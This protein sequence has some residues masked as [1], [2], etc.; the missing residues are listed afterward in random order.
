MPSHVD[1]QGSRGGALLSPCHLWWG[2]QPPWHKARP[3]YGVRRDGKVPL[4]GALVWGHYHLVTCC[5]KEHCHCVAAHKAQLGGGEAGGGVAVSPGAQAS[6]DQRSGV[7]ALRGVD[8]IC[9]RYRLFSVPCV[10]R[11]QRLY[12]PL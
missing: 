9:V 11:L 6:S 3:H 8:G 1:Q 4:H 7:V 2:R 5:A 12:G 10:R